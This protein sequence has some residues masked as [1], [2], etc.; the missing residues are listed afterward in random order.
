MRNTEPE[1]GPGAQ[2]KLPGERERDAHENA[3]SGQDLEK[4]AEG[5]DVPPEDTGTPARD[6]KSPWMGGG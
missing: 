2:E 1:A 3:G 6:R 5:R 4:P